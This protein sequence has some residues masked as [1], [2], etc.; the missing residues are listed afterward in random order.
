MKVVADWLAVKVPVDGTLNQF[1]LTHVS[2]TAWAVNGVLLVAVTERVCGAGADPPAA[3]L[4]VMHRGLVVRGPDVTA[5]VSVKV[6]SATVK[7]A[8]WLPTA[9]PTGFTLMVRV[10]GAVVLLREVL[11]QLGFP[12]ESVSD[13]VPLIV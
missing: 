8:V 7:L 13:P 2:S 1:K 10:A 5:R 9:R 3:A 11:N 6:R 12:L 4:N